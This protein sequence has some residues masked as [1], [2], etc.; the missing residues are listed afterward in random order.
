MSEQEEVLP[1]RPTD[2][3]LLVEVVLGLVLLALFVI[4]YLIPAE[5]AFAVRRWWSAPVLVGLFFVILALDAR[6]R[7][8]R[9]RTALREA[10]RRSDASGPS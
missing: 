8:Q 5:S 9:N 6:R 7:K 3:T 2:R 1:P 10:L 4:L